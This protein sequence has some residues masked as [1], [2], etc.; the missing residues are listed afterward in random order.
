MTIWVD[1]TRTK[2]GNSICSFM[3][4]DNKDEFDNILQ[5]INSIGKSPPGL[6]FCAINQK[7]KRKAVKLGAIEVAHSDMPDLM[8]QN[9]YMIAKYELKNLKIIDA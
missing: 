8:R 9:K 6:I 2:I 7:E 4:G 1:D 5:A 3:L